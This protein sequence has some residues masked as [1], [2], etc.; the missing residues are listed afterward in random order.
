MPKSVFALGPGHDACVG[1]EW[2]WRWRDVRVRFNDREV[3]RVGD[4]R[5]LRAGR[6]V[7][8]PTGE[9]LE[10]RL[11]RTFGVPILRVSKG[12]TLLQSKTP[13]QDARA[14][15][16]AQ[17]MYALSAVYAVGAIA[18]LVLRVDLRGAL[19]QGG[20]SALLASV[21]FLG[22]GEDASDKSKVSLGLAMA[23]VIAYAVRG[24]LVERTPHALSV[25][26]CVLTVVAVV[27]LVRAF[28]SVSR[29]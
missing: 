8:L 26:G 17:A 24:F 22:L 27:P 23:V 20:I 10:V 21:V 4:K 7:L 18:A 6:M 9:R 16:A 11:A 2:K 1:V 3:E 19:G 29:G 14:L 13:R 25:L 15:Q 5:A 12:G 28:V